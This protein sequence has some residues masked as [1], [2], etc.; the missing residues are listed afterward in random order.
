LRPRRRKRRGWSWTLRRRAKS[1]VNIPVGWIAVAALRLL[2]HSNR[3]RTA[4]FAG[5]SLR[6]IG[7]WLPEHRV[8]RGNLAAAFP[9]KTPAEIERILVGVWD[10]VG[11]VA[12]EFAHIDRLHIVDPERPGSEDITYDD[13]S[14]QRFYRLR[15]DTKPGLLFTAHLANW[16]LTAYVAAAYGLHATLL[17]RRPN[18]AAVSDAIIKIRADSMGTLVPNGLDAPVRLLR[19][20]QSGSLVGMLVDQHFSRGVDVT[21]FGRTCKTNPLLA[22]LAR[23][24]ECPIYGT[25]VLRLPDRNRFRVEVTEEIAPARD[26]EGRID[27]QGTM[28]IVT[29]VV[30]GWVRE[31]PDQW[32]WLHQRW[33]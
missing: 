18:I 13:E 15:S 16:E 2:R 10:N 12:A 22:Q 31:H 6:K 11:R 32:L 21:F 1:A 33:R 24:I 19:A 29:S 25:R 30:E 7:P 23:H 9:D 27:I 17:F 4:D 5:W 14:L 20:L 3:R 8:G 28:Q 26:A